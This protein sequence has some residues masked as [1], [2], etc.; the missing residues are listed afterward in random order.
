[1]LF[2]GFYKQLVQSPLVIVNL[3]I[4]ESLVI[5]DKTWQTN[6]STITRDNCSIQQFVVLLHNYNKKVL[7]LT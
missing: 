5:V 7:L 1:M 3:V 6:K 4:V 2:S